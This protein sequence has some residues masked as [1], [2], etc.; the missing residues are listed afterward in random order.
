MPYHCDD[1]RTDRWAQETLD[2]LMPLANDPDSDLVEIVPAVMLMREHGGPAVEEF[3][4]H[5]YEPALGGSTHTEKLPPWTKDPRIHFQHMTVEML[6]WQNLVFQLKIPPEQELKEAGYLQCWF[7]RPPIVNT[8]KMLEYML[9]QVCQDAE[10]VDVET[11]EEYESI[12]QMCE[13]AKSLACDTL[14]NCTGLGAKKLM[15]DD[16]LVGARGILH[17]Y[18]RVTCARRAAVREGP[19][20]DMKNDAVIMTNEGPWGSETMP[21]YLIPRS[22]TIV[23]GGSYLEGDMEE[24][25]SDEENERLLRNA[26]RLGIDTSVSKPISQWTGFRPYRPKARCELDPNESTGVRIFHSYG[27]GGSG[28]TVNVGAAKVC[29][30]ILVGKEM[31]G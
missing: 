28:W 14:V 29:A 15:G 30:D 23:V 16:E 9:E 27:Y 1:P 10:D 6:S 7:F 19:Y 25:I 2:E 12:E 18:D 4:T 3:A 22:D 31:S 13:V 24:S 5:K 21:A 11:G 26:E 20:G 17:L 8:P